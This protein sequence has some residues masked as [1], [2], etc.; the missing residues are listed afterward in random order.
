MSILVNVWSAYPMPTLVDIIAIAEAVDS[1]SKMCKKLRRVSANQIY[2][3]LLDTQIKFEKKHSRIDATLDKKRMKN[4]LRS[5]SIDLKREPLTADEL[6][7]SIG[8]KVVS[9]LITQGVIKGSDYL[10]NDRARVIVKRVH[11]QYF[12]KIHEE[13]PELA[14][15][16]QHEEVIAILQSQ[17]MD[18]KTLLH[19]Q[20]QQQKKL[21]NLEEI[22]ADNH[23]LLNTLLNQTGLG[24]I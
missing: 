18:L 6:D 8:D 19:G 5:Q 23:G 20:S 13:V 14:T 21:S 22:A 4:A 7:N 16:L 11:Q 24:P 3:N 9:I 15:I 12:T 1:L 17:N 2:I 10:D